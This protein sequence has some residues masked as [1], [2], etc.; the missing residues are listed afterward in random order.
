[1][2]RLLMFNM[3]SLDGFFETSEHDIDWHTVD[4]EFDQFATDQL[5]TVDTLLFGRITYLLMANYW[6]TQN[7][8]AEDPRIAKLM[9]EIAKVVFSRSLGK[10]DWQNTTLFSGNAG[11]EINRLKQ[12][13]GKDMIIFGSGKLV[14]S[15]A[16]LGLIDE[17]R[18]ML[19]PVIL[20]SGEPLFK[21]LKERLHLKLEQERT[22]KNG[23]ILL[24]YRPDEGEMK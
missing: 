12:L 21:G 7:A 2:R 1:M 20:G 14:S 13:P 17:Y 10:V 11:E 16:S 18:L 6:P 24:I 9:N 19:S 22:F 23:N 3:V 4:K 8:I 15:L 5:N